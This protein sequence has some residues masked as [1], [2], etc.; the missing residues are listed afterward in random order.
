MKS[1]SSRTP[2]FL[3]TVIVTFLLTSAGAPIGAQEKQDKDAP[4][5]KVVTVEGIAANIHDD[6]RGNLNRVRQHIFRINE[7]LAATDIRIRCDRLT[8]CRFARRVWVR[9]KV[10]PRKRRE[11]KGYR[12]I[13][14]KQG[15]AA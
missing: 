7:M 13:G 3:A 15:R 14:R 10:G 2:Y 4:Y 6:G 9:K 8:G 1:I 5:Q 11:R 12:V